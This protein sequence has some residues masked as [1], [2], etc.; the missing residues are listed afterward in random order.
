MKYTLE[1]RLEL[2]K[3]K[4]QGTIAEYVYETGNDCG[5]A[6]FFELHKDSDARGISVGC[7]VLDFDSDNAAEFEIIGNIHDYPELLKREVR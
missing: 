3:E 4:V 7:P 1:G 2:L 6:A 5:F